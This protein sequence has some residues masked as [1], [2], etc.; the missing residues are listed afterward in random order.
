M[1]DTEQELR[2]HLS[3]QYVAADWKPA[4]DAIFE[5]EDDSIAPFA[6]LEKLEAAAKAPFSVRV[7][8]VYNYTFSTVLFNPLTTLL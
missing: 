4:F 6:A 1:P 5:A 8:T 2:R 7:F 3:N